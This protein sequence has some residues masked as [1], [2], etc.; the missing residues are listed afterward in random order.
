MLLNKDPADA[1]HPIPGK[2]LAHGTHESIKHSANAQ[3]IRR[4]EHRIGPDTWRSDAV[5][6]TGSEG[7]PDKTLPSQRTL[8][9]RL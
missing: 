6:E 4:D 3:K 7:C 2:A 9:Y 8:V 5:A 1:A